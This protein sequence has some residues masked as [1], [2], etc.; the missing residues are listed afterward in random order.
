MVEV[1][2][3]IRKYP[4][5]YLFENPSVFSQLVGRLNEYI[6]VNLHPGKKIEKE[7]PVLICTSGHMRTATKQFIHKCV[8]TNPSCLVYFCGD[9][10]LEGVEMLELLYKDFPVNACN[11]HMDADTYRMFI[12]DRSDS[13]TARE[14]ELLKRKDFDLAVAMVRYEKKVYQEDV[15]D[16]LE[17]ELIQI[18]DLNVCTAAAGR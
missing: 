14:L 12:H 17:E 13:L 7:L 8:C 18:V 3:E 15:I 10:D 4:A 6:G 5:L 9:F 2:L 16:K 11:F 1:N